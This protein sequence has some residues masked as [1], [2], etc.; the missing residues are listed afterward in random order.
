MPRWPACTGK[1]TAQPAPGATR[2]PTAIRCSIAA[3]L[4]STSLDRSVQVPAAAA[5]A[6]ARQSALRAGSTAGLAEGCARRAVAE[7]VAEQVAEEVAEEFA[8]E[9]AKDFVPGFAISFAEELDIGL[10]TSFAEGSD[11][12]L[13]VSFAE[14][15]AARFAEWFAVEFAEQLAPTSKNTSK[16]SMMSTASISVEDRAS[17]RLKVAGPAAERESSR[18]AEAGCSCGC[19]AEGPPW[20][21]AVAAA[22]AGS[23]DAGPSRVAAALPASG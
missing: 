13:A 22:A 2:D 19:R 9:V 18:P 7:Q 10:A 23:W 1:V 4:S 15:F 17:C 8:E 12:G 14:G 21:A 3:P 6:A 20:V 11:M 5:A 16:E